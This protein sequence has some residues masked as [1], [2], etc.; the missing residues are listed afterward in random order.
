MS[1]SA[2]TGGPVA[3]D[4]VADKLKEH[5]T[6]FGDGRSHVVEQQQAA[7]NVVEDLLEAGVVGSKDKKFS[8][9]LTG[10]A[11]PNHEPAEGYGNDSISITISQ[12]EAS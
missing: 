3:T 7:K 9:S 8:V 11:N 5:T 4:Q 2:T 1:W 12:V 10:H 6:N